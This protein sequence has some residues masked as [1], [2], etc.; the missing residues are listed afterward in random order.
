MLCRVAK[1]LVW[2][3]CVGVRMT[4]GRGTSI[5][6]L[7]NGGDVSSSQVAGRSMRITLGVPVEPLEQMPWVCGGVTSGSGSSRSRSVSASH[8]R[9]ASPMTMAA[10]MASSTRCCSH[11]GRSQRTGTGV[12]PILQ[13]ARIDTTE[14]TEFCRPMATRSPT[15][16]PRSSSARPTWVLRRSSSAHVTATSV[17]SMPTKSSPVSRGRTV[18]RCRIRAP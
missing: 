14:A 4:C 5:H 1:P 7:G 18:A 11:S 17:P 8:P 12:A 15:P 9:S 16:T 13:Q 10:P 6:E 2:Y 3:S